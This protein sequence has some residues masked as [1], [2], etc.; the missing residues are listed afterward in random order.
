MLFRSLAIVAA[1]ER[2]DLPAST[3]LRATSYV[4]SDRTLERLGFR[5]RPAPALARL[6][7]ALVVVSV[8]VRLAY[9]R[10]AFTLPDLARVRQSVVP[11]G[12][13]ARRG[14]ALR[15]L[16]ARLTSVTSPRA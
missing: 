16:L 12:E 3:E 14:P 5:F 13:L 4:F 1:V 9:V 7:L 10:G 15:A 2:G 8:A 11:A 6:N